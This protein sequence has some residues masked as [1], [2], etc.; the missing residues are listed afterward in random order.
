[1]SSELQLLGHCQN[2]R[3]NGNSLHSIVILISILVGLADF[4][5]APVFAVEVCPGSS[6]TCSNKWAQNMSTQ[7]HSLD[8]CP[9]PDSGKKAIE[10]IAM[11]F[12]LMQPAPSTKQITQQLLS[13]YMQ[14]DQMYFCILKKP[15]SSHSRL[16]LNV[17]VL[18]VST[19]SLE[20]KKQQHIQ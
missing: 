3:T 2:F 10:K 14:H 15:Q 13:F 17:I 12:Q 19:N 9:R 16:A 7:C 11:P 6:E 5:G 8:Q 18:K 20:E 1:M 4:F